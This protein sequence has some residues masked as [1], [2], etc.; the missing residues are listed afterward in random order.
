MSM[1]TS[2]GS[3]DVYGNGTGKAPVAMGRTRA[4]EVVLGQLARLWV[5]GAVV[6]ASALLGAPVNAQSTKPVEAA[7]RQAK[8]QP[9]LFDPNDAVIILL[10]H[11]TGLF[12]TVKDVP[13]QELRTNTAVLSKLA[14]L[15]AIPVITTASEPG[16]PNAAVDARDPPVRTCGDVR[17]AQG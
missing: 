6:L 9:N 8:V 16:G 10:D 4:R 14:T 17:V 7:A 12:Q 2:N 3:T 1:Q 11:Q 13:L 5:S 15:A